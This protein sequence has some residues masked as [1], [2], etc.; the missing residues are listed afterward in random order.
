MTKIECINT[1]Y[2]YSFANCNLQIAFTLGVPQCKFLQV[3]QNM[4]YTY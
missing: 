3:L 2:P 1:S 4:Y